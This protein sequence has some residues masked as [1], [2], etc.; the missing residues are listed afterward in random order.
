MF[1]NGS[2]WVMHVFSLAAGATLVATSVTG[3]AFEPQG[4]LEPRGYAVTQP[5]R[6]PGGTFRMYAFRQPDAAEFVSLRSADGLA[7]ELEAGTRFSTGSGYRITD[8]FVTARG[9][10]TWLMAYKR[11]QR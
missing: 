11:E 2:T 10:G 4:V 8:P 1:W 6:L 7:W 9:D 5:V 3:L